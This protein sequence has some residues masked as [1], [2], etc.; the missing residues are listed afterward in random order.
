VVVSASINRTKES[1]MK[2]LNAHSAAASAFLAATLGLGACAS[3][4][5]PTP[6]KLTVGDAL[7]QLFDGLAQIQ[8]QQL[9]KGRLPSVLLSEASVQLALAIKDGDKQSLVI[10]M[11]GAVGSPGFTFTPFD[12]SRESNSTHMITV[13]FSGLINSPLK[14]TMLESVKAAL[15]PQTGDTPEAAVARLRAALKAL[16]GTTPAFISP[17]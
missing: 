2:D 14:D 12:R 3:P 13:K 11:P 17:R 9:A 15:Q 6:T 4:H 16:E 10:A 8:Q 1:N 7:E 5:P